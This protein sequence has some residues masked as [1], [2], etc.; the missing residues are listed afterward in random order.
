M[1]NECT[2]CYPSQADV[3]LWRDQPMNEELREYARSYIS[4][5]VVYFHTL[6]EALEH[7]GEN[8]NKEDYP[9]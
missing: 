8:F 2:E 6:D 1:A 3:V 7:I 9:E 5:P 4:P